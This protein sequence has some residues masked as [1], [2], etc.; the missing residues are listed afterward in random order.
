MAITAFRAGKFYIWERPEDLGRVRGTDDCPGSIWQWD[1]L[2]SL[3]RETGAITWAIY[4]CHFGGGSPKPTRL[5]GNIG[6]EMESAGWPTF[7][8]EGYYEG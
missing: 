8:H 3:L 5:L 2:R 7:D 6:K 4:Q 1:E